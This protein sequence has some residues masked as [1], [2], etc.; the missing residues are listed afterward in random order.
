MGRWVMEVYRKTGMKV[1]RKIER[2]GDVQE[3][4]QVGEKK[5]RKMG[6]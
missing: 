1:D 6:S 3:V 2:C 5:S 4:I